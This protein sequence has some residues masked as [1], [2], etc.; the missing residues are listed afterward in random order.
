MHVQRRIRGGD[1]MK[2]MAVL[3]GCAA[4]VAGCASAP[5][6]QVETDYIAG[7]TDFP[8]DIGRYA[9]R[10]ESELAMLY[11]PVEIERACEGMDPKFPFDS[12]RV[13]TGLLAFETFLLAFET[14][15][16]VG[17]TPLHAVET[18]FHAVEPGLPGLRDRSPTPGT[19]LIAASS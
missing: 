12:S 1:V 6:R 15:L 17:E 13:T 7:R 3:F 4:L 19:A 16:H 2:I 9:P 10:I 18:G 5:P 14:G 8:P 11:V